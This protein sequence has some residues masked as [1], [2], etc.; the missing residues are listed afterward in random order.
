MSQ[1]VRLSASFPGVVD[2][3][4]VE[5]GEVFGLLGLSAVKEFRHHK[6]FEV[7]MVTQDIY[8]M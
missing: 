2:D 3:L 7:L 1:G 6:I 8:C 5:T 4:K